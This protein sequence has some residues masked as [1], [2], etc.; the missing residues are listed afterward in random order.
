MC[1]IE[2]SVTSKGFDSSRNEKKLPSIEKK[3]ISKI[4]PTITNDK[5][6]AKKDLQKGLIII[7]VL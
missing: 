7:S 1:K 6:D 3:T 4:A 5:V 2:F